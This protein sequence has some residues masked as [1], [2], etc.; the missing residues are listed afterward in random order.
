MAEERMALLDMEASLREDS[1]GQYR[2]ELIDRLTES[3]YQ[4]KRS[5]D[6]G[7]PPDE[8]ERVNRLREAVE[9]ASMVIEKVWEAMHG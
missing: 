2:K 3:S 7:L 5:L 8:F 6:S 9:A 4:L 1:S